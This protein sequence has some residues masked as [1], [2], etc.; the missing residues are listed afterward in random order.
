MLAIGIAAAV[1][2]ANYLAG[3]SLA[4]SILFSVCNAAEPVLAVWL[5]ERWY[6]EEFK[7][8]E[9]RRVLG[10][11]AVT[12]AAAAMS[13][14]GFGAILTFVHGGVPLSESWRASFY[15]HGLGI[16]VIAPFLIELVQLRRA[17]PPRGEVI[18]G[19]TALA[20]LAL[21]VA[22][23]LTLSSGSWITLIPIIGFLPLLLWLAARCRPMFAAAGASVVSGALICTTILGVGRFGDA[24]LPLPD[25]VLAAQVAMLVVTTCTLI[26]AA[27]FA[28]RRAAHDVLEGANKRLRNQEQALAERNAQLALAGKTGLVGSYAYDIDTGTIQMSDGSAAI[29]G[30]PDGATEV[31]RSEWL[32]DKVH[33]EDRERLEQIREQ[34]FR[35]KKSEYNVDYRIVVPDRGVRWIEGRAFVTYHSNGQP[36]RV[37]GFNIDV[38]EREQA[39]E[40]LRQREAELTEAQRLAHIGNWYWDAEAKAIVGSDELIRIFGLEQF[41]I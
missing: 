38:T 13:A 36:R 32:L 41:P 34:T 8:N 5:L 17:R 12:C 28:E 10:F 6:G 24:D 18:E 16:L 30:Y 33:P 27:L 21:A 25:R 31:A 9:L 19:T 22:Y 7:F 4:T 14:I 26:L 15:A 23:V 3:R 11:L 2:A 1:I 29:H 37:V 35:Q 40:A 20:I 39:A